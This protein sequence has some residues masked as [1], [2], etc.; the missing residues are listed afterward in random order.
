VFELLDFLNQ[1]DIKLFYTINQLRSPFFD[2]TMVRASDFGIFA[3]FILAF[4]LFRL[5]R[6]SKK[7]R[8]FWIIGVVTII[9]SDAICARLLKPVFARPRP[10]LSLDNIYVYKHAK[11]IITSPEIRGQFHMNFSW[12]SCHATNIWAATFYIWQYRVKYGLIMIP[13]AVLVSYSRIYLGVHY[14]FDC[15]GGLVVGGII[16]V[17]SSYIA[18]WLS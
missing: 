8:V 3:P 2:F 15:L 11:W 4:I 1:L 17:M 14:P 13:L 16:G 5:Y 18:R 7:E 9:L 6:G 10:Y 12:P